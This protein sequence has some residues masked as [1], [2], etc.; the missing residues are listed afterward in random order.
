MKYFSFISLCFSIITFSGCKGCDDGQIGEICLKFDGI[1]V[2]PT[3]YV[4]NTGSGPTFLGTGIHCDSIR[5]NVIAYQQGTPGRTIA[6][7]D[8]NY[9]EQNAYCIPKPYPDNP[10]VPFF[11]DVYIRSNCDGNYCS[12]YIYKVESGNNVKKSCYDI[13]VINSPRNGKTFWKYSTGTNGTETTHSINPTFVKCLNCG[14][15]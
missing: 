2:V 14:C 4:I 10:A 6:F 5:V 8:K 9:L 13:N 11:L 15:I 3:E 7:Y 12:D 1:G